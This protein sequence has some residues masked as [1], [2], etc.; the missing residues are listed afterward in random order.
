VDSALGTFHLD[1]QPENLCT[2]TGSFQ[3]Q[4]TT[5]SITPQPGSW[6]TRDHKTEITKR[7]IT[8]GSH[9]CNYNLL[10]IMWSAREI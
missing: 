2:T 9:T 7:E 3:N 6:Q 4:T 1:K 8:V 10:L 5:S